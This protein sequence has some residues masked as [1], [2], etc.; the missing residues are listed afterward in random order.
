M[1][2]APVSPLIGLEKHLDEKIGAIGV[3][4]STSRGQWRASRRA[5]DT[6]HIGSQE[7]L[8]PP[9]PPPSPQGRQTAPASREPAGA[10]SLCPSRP[11]RRATRSTLATA[12]PADGWLPSPTSQKIATIE[13]RSAPAPSRSSRSHHATHTLH[14]LPGLPLHRLGRSSGCIAAPPPAI[15]LD[16]F[17]CSRT[18][19]GSSRRA[20]SHTSFFFRTPIAPVR[21]RRPARC[22]S[23]QVLAGPAISHPLYLGSIVTEPFPRGEPGPHVA[24]GVPAA[25]LLYTSYAR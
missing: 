17:T 12:H 23:G 5:Q 3:W 14:A 2:S 11:S 10:A 13:P 19:R 20:C 21:H 6:P 24:L 25:L 4:P 15:D 7:S 22:R 9:R 18:R 1:A 16:E 8:P